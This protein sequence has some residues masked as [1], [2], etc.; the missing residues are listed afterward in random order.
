MEATKRCPYCAEEILAAA[1]KCKHCNSNIDIP[2]AIPQ[3]PEG[4]QLRAWQRSVGRG[5]ILSL[6]CLTMAGMWLAGAF[7]RPK[8]TN[9]V[10][11]S[12]THDANIRNYVDQ[13]A[14]FRAEAERIARG[15]GPKDNES[16]APPPDP[17]NNSASERVTAIAPRALVPTLRDSKQPI[18]APQNSVGTS[19]I[20]GQGTE[21][22]RTE[23]IRIAGRVGLDVGKDAGPATG[24]TFRATTQQQVNIIVL[25]DI[26]LRCTRKTGID[27]AR[28]GELHACEDAETSTPQLNGTIAE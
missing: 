6:L 14:Q 3:A 21:F 20:E 11:P 10:S 27:P 22:F 17:Q 15:A 19:R 13:A 8:A 4:A 23:I 25:S 28:R 7:D 16:S 18:T 5:M 24:W 9:V 26:Y 1:V 2:S 12:A